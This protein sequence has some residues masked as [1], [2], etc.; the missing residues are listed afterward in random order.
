MLPTL[1]SLGPLHLY[2]YGALIAVGGVLS[3]VFW[4]SRRAQ[5]GIKKEDEFWLMVNVILIGGFLGGRVLFMF[6][7]VRPFS[8][9]FWDVAFAFNR[10]F[11]VMGAF[12]GVIGAIFWFSRR[13]HAGFLHVLDYVC[14][15]APFWHF[16]GRLGCLAAGCC[17]GR[18]TAVPWAVTFTNPNAMIAQEAPALLGVPVH[19]TQLYEAFGNLAIAAILFFFG[20]PRKESGLLKP[21]ALTAAYFLFYGALRFVEEFFRGD[22][23]PLGHGLTAGQGFSLAL[24]AAGLVLGTAAQ[25]SCTPS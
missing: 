1:F 22:T 11:S 4:N 8:P 6:E 18:P 13:I 16:F 15:A 17:Y 21:G 5:I 3:S 7:Y 2:S 10:G 20:L 14:V 23:V 24:I 25:N 9:E 12:F 19:P